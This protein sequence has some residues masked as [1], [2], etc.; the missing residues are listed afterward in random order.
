[1]PA[2]LC[3]PVSSILATI[4]L[5]IAGCGGDG[6]PSTVPAS[7]VVTYKGQPAEGALVVFHPTDA[8]YENRIGGKPFGKVKDDGRVALTTYAVGD[9]APEGEYAVTI[10]WNQAVASGKFSLGEEGSPTRDKLAGRYGDP[11]T[12]KF[13]FT[14]KKG[15]A[16]T[17]EIKLD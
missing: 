4:C 8:A 15:D 16:N 5:F 1:M 3:F 13:K 7:V 6:R 11:R 12:P 14:V 17:F 9:G 2:K 10:Q